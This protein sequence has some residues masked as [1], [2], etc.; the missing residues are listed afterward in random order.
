MHF[1]ILAFTKIWTANLIVQ[2][3]HSRE[4]E[5]RVS[6]DS[7]RKGVEGGRKGGKERERDRA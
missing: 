4:G 2:N 6:A 1:A 7:R 5:G 3:L